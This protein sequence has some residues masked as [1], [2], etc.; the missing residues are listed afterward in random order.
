[1]KSRFL[2]TALA[3]ALLAAAT[4]GNAL[5]SESGANSADPESALSRTWAEQGAIETGMLPD[6]SARVPMGS[7]ID[8]GD[9]AIPTAEF[10][11]VQYRLGVDDGA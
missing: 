6:P 2:F 3:T 11:G 8:S 10:G 1:M 7:R 9:T 4:A 5:A